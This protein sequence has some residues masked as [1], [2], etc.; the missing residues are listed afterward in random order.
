MT[1]NVS[2]LGEVASEAIALCV[3]LPFCQA[4]VVRSCFL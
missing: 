4:H 3:A 2:G 1:L